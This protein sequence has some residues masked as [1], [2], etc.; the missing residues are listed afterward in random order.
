VLTAQSPTVVHVSGA[1]WPTLV[2]AIVAVVLSLLALGWQAY[3]VAISG[4]RVRVSVQRGLRGPGA[5][6]TFPDD[7]QEWHLEMA[8]E[9]GL[10]QAVYAIKVANTGRGGTSV[11]GVALAFSD[12]GAL[13]PAP[14]DPPLPF[15]LDGEHEQTWYVEAAPARDYAA[16]S[17]KVLPDR[18]RNM[19]ARGR[20]TLGSAKTVFS[21]NRVRVE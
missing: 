19:T 2:L 18:A 1:G 4:S 3:S 7:A 21:S 15:R 5:V 8:R 10:T 13:L 9:Q 11:S 20:V 14:L 17:A 16:V 6:V 12:G